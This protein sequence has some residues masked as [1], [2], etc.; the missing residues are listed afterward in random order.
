[1]NNMN[2]TCMHRRRLSLTYSCK[3]RKFT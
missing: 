3:S 1:M 2:S